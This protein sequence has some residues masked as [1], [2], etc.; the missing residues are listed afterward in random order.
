ML[1]TCRADSVVTGRLTVG[2]PAR[3]GVEQDTIHTHNDDPQLRTFSARLPGNVLTLVQ[4][5]VI[6]V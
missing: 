3:H 4:C 1:L 6:I 2:A 5:N